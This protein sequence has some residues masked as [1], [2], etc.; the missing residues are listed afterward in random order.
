MAFPGKTVSRLTVAGLLVVS[1]GLAEV[2]FEV[3]HEHL[4]KGC[5]G[6]MVVDQNGITFHGAKKHS[7]SWRYQDI[8]ELKLGPGSLHLLSYRDRRLHAGADQAYDFTGAIPSGLYTFW[9]DRLDQRFVAEVADGAV[10]PLWEIP[11]KH[12]GRITGTEGIL[13][14]GEDRIVYAT[15]QKNDSRTWRF[16][17]I[18]H[19][20]NSGP[21]RL[22]IATLEETFNFQLKQVLPES[23]YNDLWLS[24]N[25]NNGRIP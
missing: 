12:L 1:S 5:R 7:W 8:Q 2:R 11:V 20:S 18:D 9:R 21:F 10:R 6:V 25:Q 13:K 3:R 15:P 24:I 14:I 22:T 23:K 16:Q 19:I 17:D 4:R